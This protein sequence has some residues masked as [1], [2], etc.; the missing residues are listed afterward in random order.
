MQVTYRTGKK[1]DFP[2]AFAGLKD[3]HVSVPLYFSF[4]SHNYYTAAAAA[5]HQA[6]AFLPPESHAPPAPALT[7]FSMSSINL[8]VQ[9]V[10]GATTADAAAAHAAAAEAC[11]ARFE[12]LGSIEE[13]GFGDALVEFVLFSRRKLQLSGAQRVRLVAA[14]FELAVPRTAAQSSDTQLHASRRCAA[15]D[16]IVICLTYRAANRA[17]RDALGAV[18]DWRRLLAAI[19]SHVE[20]HTAPRIGSAASTCDQ[21]RGALIRLAVAARVY[22]PLSEIPAIVDALE[23]DL[24]SATMR[25]DSAESFRA[26]ALLALFLPERAWPS[27]TKPLAARCL[28]RWLA[29]AAAL[30][31][32]PE[33][34]GHVLD[35]I[36]RLITF[37]GLDDASWRSRSAE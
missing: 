20:P 34:H 22:F 3:Q 36:L 32:S 16:Q 14:L 18:L 24:D 12:K 37:A 21:L 11:V 13:L 19:E 4:R 27:A 35:L 6:V 28:D 1:T 10:A 33:W 29:L 26:I 30:S 25:H 5:P 17:H 7:T 23:P 2:P 15:V 9:T 8:L 31:H